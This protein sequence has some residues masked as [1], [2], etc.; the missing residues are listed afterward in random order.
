MQTHNPQWG[1]A[2]IRHQIMT[3]IQSRV[4]AWNV[5]AG[6]CELLSTF[7]NGKGPSRVFCGASH[8]RSDVIYPIRSQ[9]RPTRCF[10]ANIFCVSSLRQDWVIHSGDNGHKNYLCTQRYFQRQARGSHEQHLEARHMNVE[11]MA[12]LEK[13]QEIYSLRT[14]EHSI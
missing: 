8:S 2:E 14:Q 12:R 1:L 6:S 11:S 10:A 9:G 3:A 4:F 13:I 7:R 5:P